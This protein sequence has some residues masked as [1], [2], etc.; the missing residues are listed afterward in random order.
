M[1]SRS[2]LHTFPSADPGQHPPLLFVHG[3]YTHAACWRK[4]FIPYFRNAGYDCHALDL[5]GHG[6][7]EGHDRLNDFGLDDYARDL[8][9]AAAV[10]EHPAVL[11]GH[12]MGA[13]VVQRHLE[14]NAAA[15]VALLSP[16]PP[17]GTAGSAMRLAFSH[18]AFFNALTDVLSDKPARHSLEALAQV[19]FSPKIGIDEVA[20]CLPMLQAE[21]S[22]AVL[23]MLTPAFW[24]AHHRQ[25]IPA[26]VMGGAEDAVFPASLLRFSAAPWNAQ[27]EIIPDAGHMLMLD[28]QWEDAARR[29][30]SWLEEIPIQS[31]TSL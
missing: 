28:P 15:G 6:E 19:Y 31:S 10:L 26:L 11:I 1:T 12:S 23:E 20:N 18:P 24:G 22:R 3:G 17:S 13:L 8:A 7:C 30:R 29:M 16:V 5:S 25:D 21:S 27:V 2:R 9:E 4:H 14:Q